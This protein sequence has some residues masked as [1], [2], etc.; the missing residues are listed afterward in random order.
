MVHA[1]DLLEVCPITMDQN[2]H[3]YYF[4]WI[5]P[6][7]WKGTV[8]TKRKNLNSPQDLRNLRHV[9]PRIPNGGWHFS[10]MGG[11]DKV[12][13]KMRSIVDGNE[14]VEKSAVN[15]TD[16]KHIE[17]VM[18][19]GKD[20]YGRKGIPESQFIP[21]DVNNIE[22]PYLKEFVKKYPHFLRSNQKEI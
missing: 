6:G 7:T 17:E 4:D 19:S 22:L 18:A 5:S 15:L 8:L 1:I 3:Y 20:L 16:K 13:N 14:M 2:F 12:I 21:Y 11:V 10:Y 9:F